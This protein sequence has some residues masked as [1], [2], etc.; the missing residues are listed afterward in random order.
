M[1]LA[2]EES[3]R[4]AMWQLQSVGA[5]KVEC[6]GNDLRINHL[7]AASGMGVDRTV[8]GLKNPESPGSTGSSAFEE[9][10]LAQQSSQEPH[11]ING[12]GNNA[13]V[14]ISDTSAVVSEKT[15]TALQTKGANQLKNNTGFTRTVRNL[16]S[17]FGRSQNQGHTE[18]GIQQQQRQQQQ[19]PDDSIGIRQNRGYPQILSGKLHANNMNQ[20]S[21][22]DQIQSSGESS[23]AMS[24]TEEHEAM[25]QEMS[26]MS[27]PQTK[28]SNRK[29]TQPHPDKSIAGASYRD[30]LE[31][32]NNQKQ[33]MGH[34]A[35]QQMQQ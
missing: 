27:V 30:D 19:G 5:D 1:Q 21:G 7:P 10:A 23:A 15:Q 12:M 14:P 22:M 16:I 33:T 17:F 32:T 34:R 26:P 11:G 6:S 24:N 3:Q 2:E 18:Q 8:H 4:V 13:M 31:Q 29:A 9:K 35:E 25:Y 28:H 20:Q